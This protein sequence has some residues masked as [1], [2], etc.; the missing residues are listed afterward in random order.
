MWG[1]LIEIEKWV[2]DD[3]KFEVS[4]LSEKYLVER[5]GGLNRGRG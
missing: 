1:L 3:S 2:S 4:F 5:L